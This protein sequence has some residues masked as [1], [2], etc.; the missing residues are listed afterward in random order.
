MTSSKPRIR[1]VAAI[2]AILIFATV[3]DVQRLPL[4]SLTD[5]MPNNKEALIN[6]PYKTPADPAYANVRELPKHDRPDLALRQFM[7]MTA[8][9]SDRQVHP[10]KAVA[11][12]R[13]A[14]RILSSEDYARNVDLTDA[15]W[16]ERGPTN[17]G[18]RTRALMF[19]PND[20]TSKKVWAAGVSG[21]LWTTDNI[22]DANTP[23]QSVDDFWANLSITA[24]DYDPSNPF[25]MYVGTGEGYFNINSIRGEGIWKT[26]DGGATWSQ[27][28]ATSNNPDFYTVHDLVV[29]SDG[30]ILV[31]TMDNGVMRSL[32][33]G[34]SWNNVLNDG[35]SN[36]AADLEV[37]S[38][39]DV[40]ATTGIF[41]P[42]NIWKSTDGGTTW[43]DILPAGYTVQ[44]IDVAVAPSNPN[45]IYAVMQDKEFGVKRIEGGGII[46]SVDAGATWEWLPNPVDLDPVVMEDDFTNGQGWYNLIISVDPNNEDHVIVG[47][48]DLFQSTNGGD[49]WEQISKQSNS[50][51]VADLDLPVVHAD[52]HAI[53]FRPGSSEEAVFGNDGGVY[54]GSN[55]SSGHINTSTLPGIGT[56]P[57]IP[58]NG[59]DDDEDDDDDDDDD[60]EDERNNNDR[61]GDGLQNVDDLDPD[62]RFVCGDSD[63]DGCDD[64]STGVFN[65][66][67]DGIDSDGDGLCNDGD[68]DDDN[69]GV[70]D[71]N[72]PNPLN[73][74][75]CG[76]SDGDTCDDCSSGAFD[77]R[78]DG[79]DSDADGICDS[80]DLDDD[81]DGVL[82]N[83]DVE[84]LNAFACGDNDG[85]GCDDCSSGANDPNNDG[86][87][88]D[89]DGLCDAGDDDDDNDG[90]LDLD[91][92]GAFRGLC[93]LC[94]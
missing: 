39:G 71:A 47:G 5:Q 54:L 33:G 65:P 66:L 49:S 55:L 62:N 30:T 59:D 51:Q 94:S 36:R 77:T 35:I 25:T 22:D 21:G 9:P 32:D 74:N 50:A 34:A 82:D 6:N 86:P 81:N 63:G 52:Q 91:D 92:R 85:D 93:R 45:V 19:D 2:C 23:W 29:L 68:L 40:Y 73:K 75:I 72:D 37:A 15:V 70:P 38:N 11:A 8:D 3:G 24:M 7:E 10:E 56:I 27:L 1:G 60:E 28:P 76:D 69:D 44:R 20:P 42:G 14:Q 89:G 58:G 43:T 90:I 78:N 53:A 41:A 64:C 16:E 79:V 46:K 61:D 84:P 48:I 13:Q 17:V 31:T 57:D 80:G 87:D 88:H 4:Y 12:F 67:D 18:G 26:T 83:D